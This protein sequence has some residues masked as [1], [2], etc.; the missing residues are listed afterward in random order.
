M[1]KETFDFINK[2][3]HLLEVDLPNGKVLNRKTYL[4]GAGR[5]YYRL[6]LKGKD[7]RLHQVIAVLLYGDKCVG[8]VVN[9]INGDTLD[10]TPANIE[11][12]TQKENVQHSFKTGLQ[13]ARRGEQCNNTLTADDVREIKQRLANGEVPYALSK[14]YGV[15]SAQIYR[16]KSGKNWSHITI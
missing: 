9:H 12:V 11:V 4:D 7:V 6:S 13:V 1:K 3:L 5:G 15:H 8:K 10:N 16:I 14:E 2:W